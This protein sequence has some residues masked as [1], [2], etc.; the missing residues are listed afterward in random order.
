MTNK[1][2]LLITG[3][4]NKY[5]SITLKLIEKDMNYFKERFFTII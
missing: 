3:T 1:E 4:Q 2:L 5:L